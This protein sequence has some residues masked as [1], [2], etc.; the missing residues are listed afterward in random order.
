M[1]LN[2]DQLRLFILGTE[3]K[4]M[5]KNEQSLSGT[6]Y[7]YW[8]SQKRKERQRQE[9][10]FEKIMAKNF[11]NLMGNNNLHIQETQ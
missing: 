8:E 6:P 11:Q 9:K 5:K 4:G 2:T 1:N 7:A 10:I 3:Q